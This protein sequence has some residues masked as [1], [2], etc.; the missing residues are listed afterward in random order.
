MNTNWNATPAS[1]WAWLG[2]RFSALFALG[3]VTY[4]VINPLNPHAQTLLLVFVAFHAVLGLRVILMDFGLNTKH[5]KTALFVLVAL[6]LAL[7]T[8]GTLWNR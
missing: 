1:M 7:L 6:G 5:Q 2:Q 3:L 4:H 8:A